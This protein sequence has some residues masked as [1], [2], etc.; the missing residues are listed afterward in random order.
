MKVEPGSEGMLNSQGRG[1][2]QT[3][4]NP[5]LWGSS[6]ASTQAWLLLMPTEALEPLACSMG[7]ASLSSSG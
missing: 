1:A 3:V 7:S 6:V 2:C 5:P 4:T